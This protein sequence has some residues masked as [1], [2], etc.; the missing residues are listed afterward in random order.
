MK[1]NALLPTYSNVRDQFSATGEQAEKGYKQNLKSH[2]ITT[3]LKLKA[4]IDEVE[5]AMTTTLALATP[6]ETEAHEELLR[7]TKDNIQKGDVRLKENK[8]KKLEHLQA[9][10]QE[11]TTPPTRGGAVGKG[12]RGAGRG[13]PRPS[14]ATPYQ[15]DQLEPLIDEIMKRIEQRRSPKPRP[16]PP[17]RAPTG[18]APMDLEVPVLRLRIF[19]TKTGHTQGSQYKL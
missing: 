14:R 2:Y 17:V 3:R 8:S 18:D 13:R 12:R 15:P 7:T 11:T 19:G 1:C 4:E 5:S 16:P 6:Q 9:Q 10:P